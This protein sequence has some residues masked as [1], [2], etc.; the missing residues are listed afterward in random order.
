MTDADLL[1][2]FE[3][4]LQAQFDAEPDDRMKTFQARHEIT[5]EIERRRVKEIDEAGP[6]ERR[7]LGWMR[8]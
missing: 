2:A 4:A 8:F 5:M 3:G 6:R 7:P 1:R